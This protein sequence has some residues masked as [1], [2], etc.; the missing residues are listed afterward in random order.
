MTTVSAHYTA[1]DEPISKK[2][3][4]DDSDVL[5]FGKAGQIYKNLTL[6]QKLAL[7]DYVWAQQAMEGISLGKALEPTCMN[8]TAY[9]EM[10]KNIDTIKSVVNNDP[11]L[12]HVC[13]PL[14]QILLTDADNSANKMELHQYKK[15]ID[16]LKKQ[17]NQRAAAAEAHL[18]VARREKNGVEDSLR[19]VQAELEDANELTSQQTL[20]TDIWQGRF[21]EV[22]ELA[23]AAG[24]DANR[25]F[26]IRNR[27]LSSGL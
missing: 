12:L 5:K 1:A 19:E 14:T 25:L 4:Q 26:E 6:R 17:A 24:V 11:Q 13:W 10:K 22:F 8:R 20:A 23:R 18:E 2:Q 15:E 16:S 27:P 7:F 3:K 21:D 9:Y